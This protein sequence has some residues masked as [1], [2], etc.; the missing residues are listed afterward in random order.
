MAP[1]KARQSPPSVQAKVEASGPSKL[2]SALDMCRITSPPSSQLL[3][4]G[5]DGVTATKANPAVVFRP[6]ALLLGLQEKDMPQTP[7]GSGHEQNQ[8]LSSVY[9]ACTQKNK[10]TNKQT[11][12]QANTSV[13]PE[14]RAKQV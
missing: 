13:S 12:K 4:Q 3:G 7:L 5:W 9:S 10:Q 2:S 14:G 8:L 6:G 11:N 1:G